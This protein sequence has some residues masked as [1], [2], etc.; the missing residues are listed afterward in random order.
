[1]QRQR[2]IKGDPRNQPDQADSKT[3]QQDLPD[4]TDVVAAAESALEAAQKQ[5]P[6]PVM[7]CYVCGDPHCYLAPRVPI[8]KFKP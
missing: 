2:Q 1:M 7:V 5:K 6:A 4:V 3:S 8:H